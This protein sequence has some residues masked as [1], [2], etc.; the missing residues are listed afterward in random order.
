MKS[1]RDRH[2]IVQAGN[3]LF[4]R[5][6]CLKN[7]WQE[8]TRIVWIKHIFL[9]PGNLKKIIIIT[10]SLEG[11]HDLNERIFERQMLKANHLKLH[12]FLATSYFLQSHTMAMMI[13]QNTLTTIYITLSFCV[14][15]ALLVTTVVV[16]LL[17]WVFHSS[18]VR[19]VCVAIVVRK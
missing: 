8:T 15:H 17:V 5:N 2:W 4:W 1:Q 12:F 19:R 10:N 18:Y 6:C 13:Y 11:F 9:L 16:V 7:D 14:P 3:R